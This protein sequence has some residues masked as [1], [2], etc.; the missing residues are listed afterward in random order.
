[1]FDRFE[2]VVPSDVPAEYDEENSRI[3]DL[4]PDAFSERRERHYEVDLDESGWR[5]FE[6]A[7]DW[8]VE[9]RPPS[10]EVSG[11]F[12]PDGSFRLKDYAFTHDAKMNYRIKS[13][14]ERKRLLRPELDLFPE[15]LGKEGFHVVDERASRLVLSLIAD[16][17]AR[18]HRLRTVT[19]EP[20]GF[21]LNSLNAQGPAS[22]HDAS[23]KLATAIIST[24]VP[25][26]VGLL[27]ANE[28]VELRNRF[29][30]MRVPF[31]RA[32]RE[33]CDDHMLGDISDANQ[34]EETIAEI[35][36]EYGRA[37]DR[38]RNTRFSKQI[39]TWTSLGLGTLGTVLS[40][41]GNFTLGA[42]GS[43]LS[44]A[45]QCLDKFTVDKPEG[46]IELS[47]RLICGLRQELLDP[48]LVE[49]L[50]TAV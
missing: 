27:S 10:N 40:L 5:R 47:Q 32:V 42:I 24:E 50:A 12:G 13:F 49:R 21:T 18:R 45:V 15:A 29:E 19:D 39:K 25:E 26:T 28:Y 23:A 36:M 37:T 17:L 43:G 46:N 4:L 44:V 9:Q 3:I 6:Q 2:V 16:T 33:L 48:E 31:Q 22:R 11:L 41:T 14:L 1:M 38:F 30:E 20:L 8:L 34:L 35:A 7:L